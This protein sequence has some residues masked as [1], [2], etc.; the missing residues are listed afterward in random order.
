MEKELLEKTSNAMIALYQN[1]EIDGL[2][3]VKELLPIYQN[4]LQEMVVMGKNE[5]VLSF[6]KIVKELVRHFQD[7]NMIGMAD[8]LDELMEWG[9]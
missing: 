8:C 9:K 1:K 6:F 2:K 4:L 5:E 3:M 7:Q